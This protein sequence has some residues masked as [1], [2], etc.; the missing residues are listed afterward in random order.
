MEEKYRPLSPF[1]YFGYN[2]LFL[3]P[4][5][6]LAFLVIFSFNDKNLNRRNYARSFF[7]GYI[8]FFAV[9]AFIY[10]FNLLV[11]KIN[12]TEIIEKIRLLK[13]LV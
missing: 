5:I 13:D 4:V 1:E 6:G 8:L 3:V 12:I 9:S 10:V 2:L 7:C 11:F